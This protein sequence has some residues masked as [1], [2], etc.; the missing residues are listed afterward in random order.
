MAV[1]RLPLVARLATQLLIGVNGMLMQRVPGEFAKQVLD[2]CA[3]LDDQL[4]VKVAGEVDCKRTATSHLM[5]SSELWK[6]VAWKLWK[7]PGTT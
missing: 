6:G 5:R 7:V 4:I 1:K 2:H 3:W